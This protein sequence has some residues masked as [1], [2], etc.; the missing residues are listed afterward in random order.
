MRLIL[1]A[2]DDATFDGPI[3]AV[4]PNPLTQ[5][6]FIRAL[7]ANWRRPVSFGMPSRILRAAVGE[8]SDLF[9]TS[10]RAVPTAALAAGFHFEHPELAGAVSAIFAAPQGA[11]SPLSVYFDEPCPVCRSEMGH[12]RAEAGRAGR[13]IE[14]KPIGASTYDV[15]AYG[16]S[17]LD[18]QRR[19]YLTDGEGRMV[20]GVDAFLAL[21]SELPRYRRTAGVL[22]LPG[23]YQLAD[24]VYE[25]VCVPVLLVMN[26]RRARDDRLGAR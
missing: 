22:A 4:A 18:L 11:L 16:L 15:A 13:A 24:L 12:Y 9:L 17:D 7:A 25:G 20:S 2:I 26:R 14:F 8:L 21:W 1:F 23:L 3:N 6:D 5:R 19:L 10:Q